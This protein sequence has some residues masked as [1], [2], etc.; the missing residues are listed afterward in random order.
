MANVIASLIPQLGG[1]SPGCSTMHWATLG[2]CKCNIQAAGACRCNQIF[3]Q[4]YRTMQWNS[5]GLFTLVHRLQLAKSDTCT[6]KKNKT[7]FQNM[8]FQTT[9]FLCIH[10]NPRP[11]IPSPTKLWIVEMK[12]RFSLYECCKVSND[13]AGVVFLARF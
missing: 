1:R 6:I 5:A 4:T 9:H 3:H 8:S 10:E 7:R 13:C 2:T 12:D 11:Q